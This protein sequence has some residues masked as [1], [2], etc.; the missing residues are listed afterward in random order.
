MNE[1]LKVNV[2]YGK[3]D[4]SH[5]PYSWL[6]KEVQHAT[7]KKSN[8]TAPKFPGNKGRSN[9]K[10]DPFTHLNPFLFSLS[11]YRTD[12]LRLS[13]LL[14]L[15]QSQSNNGTV[16]AVWNAI[17]IIYSVGMTILIKPPPSS[18]KRTSLYMYVVKKDTKESNQNLLLILV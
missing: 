12:F 4:H 14:I 10:H 2:R 17:K 9:H 11:N 3:A 16:H 18:G 1:E 15:L 13:C 5:H 6:D 8:Q 7:E